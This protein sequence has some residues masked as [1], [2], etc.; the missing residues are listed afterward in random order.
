MH[1]NT[2]IYQVFPSLFHTF[3]VAKDYLSLWGNKIIISLKI[4]VI[5]LKKIIT[6]TSNTKQTTVLHCFA[7]EATKPFPFNRDRQTDRQTEM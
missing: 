7:L 1:Y 2:Y 6:T 4:N 3:Y 5:N